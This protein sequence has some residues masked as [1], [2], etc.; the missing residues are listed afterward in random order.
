MSASEVME[1][2][3]TSTGAGIILGSTAFILLWVVVWAF[4]ILKRS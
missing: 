4:S 1:L 3:A 2:F